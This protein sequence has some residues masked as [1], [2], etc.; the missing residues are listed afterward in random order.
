MIYC[1]YRS[2]S[3]WPCVKI[4]KI[5][6]NNYLVWST[7]R[8][9][10]WT[11]TRQIWAK[12]STHKWS[13]TRADPTWDKPR[14]AKPRQ[15]VINKRWEEEEKEVKVVSRTCQG[16]GELKLAFDTK[17]RGFHKLHFILILVCLTLLCNNTKKQ[18]QAS[19]KK[20]CNKNNAMANDSQWLRM[21]HLMCVL[22]AMVVKNLKLLFSILSGRNDTV[23]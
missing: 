18:F 3:Q 8:L 13:K 19:Y 10:S 20:F 5:L 23:D 6:Q 9:W 21:T 4:W 7:K 14:W 2:L 22:L 1:S 12:I 16:F 15:A 17:D 11:E